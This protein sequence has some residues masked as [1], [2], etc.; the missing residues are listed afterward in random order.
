LDAVVVGAKILDL[1]E[2]GD[3]SIAEF[4]AQVYKSSKVTKGTFR[5]PNVP[6][7][8]RDSVCHLTRK[9]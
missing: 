3:K 6:L 5:T 9:C 8:L 7:P 4:A 1:C 2:L